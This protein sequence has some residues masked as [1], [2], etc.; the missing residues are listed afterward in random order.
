MQTFP[1]Q[2]ESSVFKRKDRKA[3]LIFDQE[4]RVTDRRSGA[5]IYGPAA[6]LYQDAGERLACARIADLKYGILLRDLALLVKVVNSW[7][8]FH[9]LFCSV[10]AS[11]PCQDEAIALR[12]REGDRYAL[13]EAAVP[14]L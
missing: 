12:I 14:P 2:N 5:E 9:S 13:I 4:K 1:S 11:L 6:E 8:A 10:A 3:N 7:N